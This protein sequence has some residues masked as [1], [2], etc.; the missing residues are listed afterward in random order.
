[1]MRR[2]L[3]EYRARG[4]A[5][6]A[7]VLVTLVER[8][9]WAD[10]LE[11]AADHPAVNEFVAMLVKAERIASWGVRIGKLAKFG[12][13]AVRVAGPVVRQLIT[14]AKELNPFFVGGAERNFSVPPCSTGSRPAC[15]WPRGPGCCGSRGVAR[16]AVAPTS[17]SGSVQ[18][19]L[20]RPQ[21]LL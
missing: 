11:R 3:Y 16:Q 2:A 12:P 17:A 6:R 8:Q 9:A 4:A 21:V 10:D 5:V 13:A 19:D 7:A 20:H 14:A 15:G 18:I 1:M